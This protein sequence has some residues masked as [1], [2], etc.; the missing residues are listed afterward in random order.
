[1]TDAMNNDANKMQAHE[2]TERLACNVANIV[3]ESSAAARAL[4]LL[5]DLRASGRPA[6]IE[7]HGDFWLVVQED[8]THD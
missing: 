7:Q 8:G 3:G 4:R 2:L 6:H 1:M 5:A